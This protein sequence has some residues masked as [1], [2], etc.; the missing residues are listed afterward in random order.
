MT[1]KR[2]PMCVTTVH[3]QA[4]KGG[5]QYLDYLGRSVPW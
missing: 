1:V 3:S 5:L 4:G 2:S